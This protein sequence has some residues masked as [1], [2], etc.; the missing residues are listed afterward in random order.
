M[1]GRNSRWKKV[2][3][4]DSAQDSLRDHG[5]QG[6]DSQNSYPPAAVGAPC[7][8]RENNRQQANKFRHHAMSVLESNPAHHVRDLVERTEGSRPIGNRQASII[9]GDQSSGY[10]EHKRGRSREYS[11]AVQP[12]IVRCENG[13]QTRL[14][15]F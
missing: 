15:W 1:S 10:D 2:E 8:D 11:E 9:A 5:A 4:G 7:P 12:A 3:H 13:L 6:S 14:P